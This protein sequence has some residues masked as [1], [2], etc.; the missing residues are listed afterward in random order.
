MSRKEESL[1]IYEKFVSNFIDSRNQ[2]GFYLLKM[3][4]AVAEA[5]HNLSRKMFKRFLKDP[6][7]NVQRL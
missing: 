5:K 7:I 3:A 6:R 1:E 4:Q 2:A